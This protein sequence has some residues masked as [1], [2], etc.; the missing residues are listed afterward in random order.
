MPV[1][2]RPSDDGSWHHQ[3]GTSLFPAS[4]S[5][6]HL[7]IGA[8]CPYAH[9]A[10]LARSLKGLQ[11]FLPVSIVKPYTE[12]PGGWQF[13]ATDSEHPGSTP[14]HLYHSE[15]LSELYFRSD[16]DY[17]GKYTVPM[18]WDKE[19]EQVVNNESQDIMRMLFSAFNDL[20]PA[21]KTK[22]R[23]L[24]FYPPDLRP[25]ID[26]LSSWMSPD[27]AAGVYKAGYAPT[28]SAYAEAAK[29]VFA[30][31]ERFEHHLA[32]HPDYLYLL[33]PT[34]ITEADLK[35]YT[36]LIRFNPAFHPKFDDG[37][38]KVGEKAPRV[39]RWLR[40]LFWKVEGVRETTDFRAMRE[41]YSK[42]GGDGRVEDVETF[43]E[44][45]TE[46]D[47]RWRL[48]RAVV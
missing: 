48:E 31:L 29:T 28:S 1:N 12:G 27:L 20:L 42:D 21:D 15:F 18:L 36:T 3:L 32:Q 34:R 17:K 13:P 6:Y 14:D 40:H 11:P 10:D 41:S 39:G 25:Q 2:H 23:E 5:R 19:T 43:V 44:P 26:E 37:V 46:E 47:E 16:P 22:Q 4:P 9:R 33:S 30:A 7:Y 35:L 24:D 38:G 8:F 45:W